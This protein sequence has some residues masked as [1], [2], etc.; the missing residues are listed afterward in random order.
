[1]RLTEAIPVRMGGVPRLAPD[2]GG[3]DPK[4]RDPR[5][6]ASRAIPPRPCLPRA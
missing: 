1:M 2:G 6:G 3:R 5:K 4:G